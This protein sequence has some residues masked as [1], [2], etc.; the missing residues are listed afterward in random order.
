MGRGKIKRSCLNF[1]DYVKSF[2]SL[3]TFILLSLSSR[4]F[5]LT[6]VSVKPLPNPLTLFSTRVFPFRFPKLCLIKTSR[7]FFGV[8]FFLQLS[9]LRLCSIVARHEKKIAS[10]PSSSFFLIFENFVSLRNNWIAG[11]D[12][13]IVGEEC[14]TA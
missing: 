8:K 12:S 2:Q 4:S 9:S 10:I 3:V 13:I 5:I 14:S 11:L 6:S 1:Y 7:Q